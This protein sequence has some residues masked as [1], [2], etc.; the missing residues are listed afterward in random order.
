M[1]R[2]FGKPSGESKPPCIKMDICLFFDRNA[3]FPG[4]WTKGCWKRAACVALAFENPLEKA[5]G[6]R[7]VRTLRMSPCLSYVRGGGVMSSA[8]ESSKHFRKSLELTTFSVCTGCVKGR[9]R[10]TRSSI[11]KNNVICKGVQIWIN[12]CK[13]FHPVGGVLF[14]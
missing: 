7:H 1:W 11:V 9:S 8:G 14:I 4:F 12:K 3:E 2:L 6:D 10:L 13:C 5:P